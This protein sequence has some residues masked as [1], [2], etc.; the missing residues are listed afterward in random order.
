MRDQLNATMLTNKRYCDESVHKHSCSVGE[1]VW[2]Y[3]PRHQTGQCPK[4]SRLYSGPFRV[5]KRLSDIRYVTQQRPQSQP[6]V[7]HVDKLKKY[8]GTAPIDWV[9]APV[10]LP[11]EP[12][13]KQN[14]DEGTTTA[15]QA[16]HN[17]NQDTLPLLDKPHSISVE[18]SSTH[19]KRA[20]AS[21]G[22]PV[23]VESCWFQWYVPVYQCTPDQIHLL[24][25]IVGVPIIFVQIVVSD[26]W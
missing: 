13:E 9:N 19:V 1:W 11:A 18:T 21:A 25:N 20:V 12:V 8:E 24:R 10:N 23:S 7:T 3:K 2:F 14:E 5:M 6:I 22:F 26:R 17:S 16:E 15:Q 4:W